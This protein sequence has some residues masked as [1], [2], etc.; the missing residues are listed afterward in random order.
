MDKLSL[1]SL[2][3]TFMLVID[4]G[5]TKKHYRHLLTKKLTGVK[6]SGKY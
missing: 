6:S 3:V 4:V 1:V 5:E 2:L